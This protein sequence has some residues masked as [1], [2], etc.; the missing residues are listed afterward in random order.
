MGYFAPEPTAAYKELGLSG[1]AGYFA[2]RSAPMGAVAGQVVTATFYVF[3]PGLVE[4]CIPKAWTVASPE[5]VLEARH[6]AMTALLHRVFD[7]AEIPAA[8]LDEALSLARTA[9]EG[10]TAQGRA[11]YAGHASLP[12]PTDPLLALWHAGTLLREHR[13]D[14]HVATLLTHELDPLEA[15]VTYGKSSG[16]TDFLKLTRGWSDEEWAAAT[17][18]C[19]ERGL[20]DESG[21]LTEA[22]VTQRASVE[23][24]TAELAM[25]GWEHLG[26]EGA[27]RLRDLIT[28]MRAAM[29]SSGVFP[30]G[31]GTKG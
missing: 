11:L 31:L 30:T 27:L 26:Q 8:D 19:Q 21:E 20:I 16:M 15:M 4:H 17:V 13:G 12:W 7:P 24:K 3:S 29:A 2:C 28:P 10:L 14:G 25:Q 23:D 9:T 1:R 18:R 22:G 5:Q 6:T